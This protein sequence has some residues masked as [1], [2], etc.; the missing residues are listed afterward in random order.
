MGVKQL[1][2]ARTGNDTEEAG[3]WSVVRCAASHRHQ[4]EGATHRQYLSFSLCNMQSLLRGYDRI[5]SLCANMLKA[6][7]NDMTDTYLNKH[8]ERTN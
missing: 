1:L 6:C 5:G 3:H 7:E 2:E 8:Y 4:V